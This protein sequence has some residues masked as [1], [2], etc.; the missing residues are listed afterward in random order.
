MF[1]AL[2]D[3]TSRKRQLPNEDRKLLNLD[4]N[5]QLLFMGCLL[6]TLCDCYY[7]I[8]LHITSDSSSNHAGYL[9]HPQFMD[10]ET[11]SEG[12]RSKK[13]RR[14]S[15]SKVYV[16]PFCNV[17]IIWGKT[18]TSLA[19]V[20]DPIRFPLP[21]RWPRKRSII[22]YIRW[23]CLWVVSGPFT[24]SLEGPSTLFTDEETEAQWA[25]KIVQ[26]HQRQGWAA[27]QLRLILNP[28][29]FPLWDAS[30][31]LLKH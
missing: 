22:Y 17:L 2:E 1:Y 20:Q 16:F 7:G 26:S 6:H 8:Y 25:I 12:S 30:Q 23:G 21:H 14:L 24:A 29:S 5:K 18:T 28:G 31:G 10:K 13:P 11:D 3:T 9:N 4:Y 27:A 19:Q 15:G